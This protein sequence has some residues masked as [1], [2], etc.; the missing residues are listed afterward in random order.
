MTTADGSRVSAAFWLLDAPDSIKKQSQRMPDGAGIGW[1]SLGDE[2]VKDRSPLSAEASADFATDA[3]HVRSHTFIA[4]VRYACTGKLT[5]HNTHPFDMKDRLFAHNGVVKNLEVM[6]GWM[7][8]MEKV[9]IEGQ[10]DSEKVFA[11]ITAEIDRNGGD[12]EAGIVSAVS[13]IGAELPVYALNIILAE[14]RKIYALRYP[15]TH[16]LWVLEPEAGLFGGTSDTTAVTERG[17]LSF[18]DEEPKVPAFVIAS[19][20]LDTNPNWRLLEPYEMAVID[21]G[22][23]RYVKPFKDKAKIVLTLKDL[24]PQE[25]T[26]QVPHLEKRFAV[27]DADGDGAIDQND[28]LAMAGKVVEGYSQSVTPEKAKAVQDAYM[29]FWNAISGPMD[30]DHSGQISTEELQSVISSGTLAKDESF[31]DAVNSVVTAVTNLADTDGS[32]NISKEEFEELMRV[33]GADG[34]EMFARIDSDMSG[35]LSIE[36]LVQ[37]LSAFY[38]DENPQAAANWLLGDLEIG[39][40]AKAAVK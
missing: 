14:P 21:N 9:F 15:E 31:K 18:G 24:S 26:S 34:G 40:S 11:L 30:L 19:E 23:A 13:R 38:S 39:Y 8:D 37:A 2:P 3:T 12:T 25:A 33:L 29:D 7:T 32:G 20:P 17:T 1:F 5:V 27:L 35:E 16:E 4:H 28:Y 22:V 10:T 36:E 6:E